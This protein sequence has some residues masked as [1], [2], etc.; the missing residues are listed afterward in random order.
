MKWG[1]AFDRALQLDFDFVATGHHARIVSTPTG[2]A[3]ARGTDPAKDQSYVLYMLGPE[4][5][6]RTLLPIGEMTKA[7]VR[8]HAAALGLRTASKRESMDVCFI[9]RGGRESFLGA[10]IPRRAGRV[11]DTEGVEVATHDGIDAFTIG[12]R[13]GVNVAVGERRYVVDISAADGTVTVGPRDSLLRD[14]VAVRDLQLARPLP[15]EFLVQTR[16]HGVVTPARWANDHVVFAS[17]Q[18][19]VAP[20]QVIACYDG[21]VCCGGG[22]V[23]A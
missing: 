21:D 12:Q 1:R 11:V 4:Q 22:I 7:E 23:A 18:P 13:R 16:A 8:E 14:R 5:L 15:D 6:G 10:R 3:L 20:G 19:R 9:T 17:P 2:P